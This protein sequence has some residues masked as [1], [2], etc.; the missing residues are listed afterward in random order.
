MV[1]V[2]PDGTRIVHEH[3]DAPTDLITKPR[4]QV[5]DA[6]KLTCCFDLRDGDDINMLA[7]MIKG[8]GARTLAT[9]DCGPPL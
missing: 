6:G 1:S 5:T 7:Q 3:N 4:K 2:T 9:C 8:R